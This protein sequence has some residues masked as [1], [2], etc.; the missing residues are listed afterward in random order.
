IPDDRW[1]DLTNTRYLL[2]DKVY[3]VV[4]E[5]IFFDT[6][7]KRPTRIT[8]DAPYDFSADEV[9]VL[10]R[11]YGACESPQILVNDNPTPFTPSQTLI[12]P[13][14]NGDQLALYTLDEVL[15]PKNITPL[16][17]AITI[18]AITLVDSRT[19]DFLQIHPTGW[20]RVYSADIKI[21]ENL[22]VMPRAFMVYDAQIFP[23]TWD[24]T[25]L[26][27]SA[28][29]DEGFNPRTSMTINTNENLAPL[30]GAGVGVGDVTITRYTSTEIVMTVE[31]DVAG[32]VGLTDATYPNWVAQVDGIDAPIFRADVM[33]RAVYV[34]AG[35]HEVIMQY[36]GW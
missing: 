8:W 5:G 13:T 17:E 23:D 18:V 16:G 29:R 24:G 22:D 31:T 21:Y 3:D 11:C 1:L 9:Q 12:P 30:N 36:R 7:F 20:A 35:T 15:I 33:F 10:F 26:A 34:E 2:T 28:M 19:G 14:T 25:E 4:H 6:Q 27:L 32:D